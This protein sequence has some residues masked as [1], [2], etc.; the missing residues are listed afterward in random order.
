MLGTSERTFTPSLSQFTRS[1]WELSTPNVSTI[2]RSRCI[3]FNSCSAPNA[4]L[5][6]PIMDPERVL[7]ALLPPLGFGVLL[8]GL[9]PRMRDTIGMLGIFCVTGTYTC[10][11]KTIRPKNC[12]HSIMTENPRKY[13]PTARVEIILWGFLQARIR[14][15]IIC[16]IDR[17]R[18]CI[19]SIC[20]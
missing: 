10:R 9:L 1:N 3:V 18:A 14:Y 20:L 16:I 12:F 4:G 2:L 8:R 13:F 17:S 6:L 5:L 19:L 7:P 15:I 11:F